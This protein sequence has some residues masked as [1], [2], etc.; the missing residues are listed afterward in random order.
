VHE[1]NRLRRLD[2][3]QERA[4]EPRPLRDRHRGEVGKPFP[5]SF[6][7]DSITGAIVSMWC[8]EAS[9]GTTPP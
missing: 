1:G 5:E 6:I 2:A 3:H 7:A 4:H 9:S 8:R